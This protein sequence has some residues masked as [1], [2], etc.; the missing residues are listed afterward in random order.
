M[1]CMRFKGTAILGVL[2][3]H[4]G[5]KGLNWP[6]KHECLLEVDVGVLCVSR[7]CV[8]AFG[9]FNKCGRKARFKIVLSC[10]FIEEKIRRKNIL[11]KY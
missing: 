5:A 9:Y 4:Y 1:F 3:G 7:G 2:L 11:N 6:D 8:G 10:R